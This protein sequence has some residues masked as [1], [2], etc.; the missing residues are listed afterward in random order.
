[1]KH[2][3]IDFRVITVAV[4]ATALAACVEAPPRRVVVR[5]QMPPPPVARIIVYPA[6]GQSPEQLERDRYECHLWSVKETGFDPSRPG[7][8]A[9][10]RVVVEPA[11]APGAGTAVGA[12]AG[13]ILGAAVAGPRN[14][15]GGA[16][17][18]AIAGGAVGSASE[19][20]ANAQAAYEQS[21][22]DRRAGRE[23]AGAA[24]Y[25]RAMGACLEARGYTTA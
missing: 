11:V 19:A 17:V 6:H 22:I 5:D 7:V 8:P 9:N 4:M 23:E 13:A 21:R 24:S 18:G 2:Q 20:N 16:I 14:A 10:E 15:G 25:R 3:I 1:M 12:V